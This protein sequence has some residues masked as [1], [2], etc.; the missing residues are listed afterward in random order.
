MDPISQG[1]FGALWAR[2]GVEVG[3]RRFKPTDKISKNLVMAV[4]ALSGMA[5]DLDVLISS[6]TDPLLSIEYHRH[7]THALVFIPV[8]ALICS[9]F[10]WT[11]LK[12][13]IS[14]FKFLYAICFLGY[15][16]HGL[17][18]AF[19]S[20]GTQLFWP[21]ANTRVAW[22][23]I[24]IVDPLFTLPLILLLLYNFKSG[25]KL[26]FGFACLYLGLGYIQ[27]ERSLGE[28]GK[29]IQSRGHNGA[30]KVQAKPSFGNLIVFRGLYQYQDRFY[31][32]AVRVGASAKVYQG[33]SLPAFNPDSLSARSDSKL[34]RDIK[35]FEWFSDGFLAYH[36]SEPSVIGDFR[37]SMLPNT[38]EPLWGIKINLSKPDQH[39]EFVTMRQVRDGAFLQLFNMIA[40]GEVLTKNQV[41]KF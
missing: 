27:R 30:T 40:G 37:Y 6:N 22:D 17:L 15:A 41:A 31:A 18:D 36:P 20:Y 33:D 29:L 28:L 26:A 12:K 32:D 21:F 13:K 24:S 4:G 10:F 25:A 23:M 2:F 8:G 5:A 9:L 16:S 38:V 11:L 7:F 14:S 1:V 35:R 34:F 3:S 39:V 19:T